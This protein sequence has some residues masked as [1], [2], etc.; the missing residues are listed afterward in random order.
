MSSTSNDPVIFC[1]D[2]SEGA[3][4]A[5]DE[6]RWL[7]TDRPAVVVCVWESARED[8]RSVPL[9]GF[10]P[11]LVEGMDEAAERDAREIATR[12]AMLVPHAQPVVLKAEGSIWRTVLVYA[13]TRHAATIVV[14]SRGRGGLTAAI[15]GSV[16]RGVL[17]HAHRPVLVVPAPHRQPQL[18][19]S[20]RAPGETSAMSAKDAHRAASA[21]VSQ[22]Q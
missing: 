20:A 14:G 5:L 4:R 1:Y 17:D 3:A 22:G 11:D 16:S 9:A 10:P 2:G 12:G 18:D 8:A 15:L 21:W 19:A 7:G 13:E 6:A